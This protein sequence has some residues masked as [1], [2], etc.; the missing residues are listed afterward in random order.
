MSDAKRAES[1]CASMR[2]MLEALRKE[3]ERKEK[4]LSDLR[5]SSRRRWQISRRAYR[6]R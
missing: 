5:E 6:E 1:M 4:R 3:I 2:R